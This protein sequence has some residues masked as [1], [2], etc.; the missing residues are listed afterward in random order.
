[1]KSLCSLS[2]NGFSMI[3]EFVRKKVMAGSE[4]GSVQ[5]LIIFDFPIL[6]LANG[7]RCIWLSLEFPVA[8]IKFFPVS[9]WFNL[10]FIVCHNLLIDMRSVLAKLEVKAKRTYLLRLWDHPL[11]NAFLYPFMCFDHRFWAFRKRIDSRHERLSAL[12]MFTKAAP[13]HDKQ[14][15]KHPVNNRSFITFLF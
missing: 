11:I 12:F 4:T 5:T 15:T 2:L 13:F 3:G 9:N 6:S 7:K 1:M 8:W 14:F 10:Q